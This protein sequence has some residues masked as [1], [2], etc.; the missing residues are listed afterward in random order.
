MTDLERG[1]VV[2][3]GQR[4]LVVPQ[5]AYEQMLADLAAAGMPATHEQL[6]AEAARL[7]GAT[8]I[9]VIDVAP[10]ARPWPPV[11]P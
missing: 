3:G 6:V 10:P 5:W 1:G 9:V 4:V 2:Q 11:R 7:V 8:G